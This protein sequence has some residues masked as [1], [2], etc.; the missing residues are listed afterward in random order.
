MKDYNNEYISLIVPTSV[1]IPNLK[2]SSTS[3]IFSSKQIPRETKF[4][5]EKIAIK[6]R[7]TNSQTEA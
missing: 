4:I 6:F 1:E 5:S 3:M 2:L 7:P